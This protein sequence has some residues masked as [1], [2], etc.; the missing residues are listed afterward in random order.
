MKFRNP[1]TGEVFDSIDPKL[2][3]LY[4]SYEIEPIVAASL[5]GFEVITDDE[6]ANMEK[7]DKFN[8]A[9]V[10]GVEE[11]ERW[12]Y[13]TVFGLFRVHNGVRE[14]YTDDNKWIPSDDEV[15]LVKILNHP[16]HIIRF[17]R[18]TEAEKAICKALGAKWVSRDNGTE[19]SCVEMWK[20]KPKEDSIGTYYYDIGGNTRIAAVFRNDMFFSIK[21]GDCICVEEAGA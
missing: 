10:L 2:I 4:G 19:Y 17:P 20:E 8:L 12:T 21:P 16:E 13:P 14:H 11:D 5:I 9:E 7:K 18:L 6:E 15:G 3:P 1:K